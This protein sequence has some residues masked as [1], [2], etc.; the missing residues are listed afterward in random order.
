MSCDET[1]AA[2]ERIY[3]DKKLRE[4]MGNAA[5]SLSEI[6]A[7]EKIYEQIKELVETKKR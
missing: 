3:S 6:N 4:A 5:A 7:A 1:V 2:V